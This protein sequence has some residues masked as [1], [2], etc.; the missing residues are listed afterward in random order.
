LKNSQMRT[1]YDAIIVGGGPAGSTAAILLARAGWSVAVIEKQVFPRRKVCGECIAATNLSLLHELGI[2]LQFDSLAGSELRSVGLFAGEEMLQADLP[3][4]AEL[5][6]PWGR[7]LGRE[8]L[9]T[10]LLERAA[11]SGAQIWQPWTLK[12]MERDRNHGRICHVVNAELDATATVSAPVLIAAHGSWEPD[13]FAE[14]HKHRTHR[15]SDLFAFKGTFRDSRL[16]PGLLPVLAFPGGYGGMVLGDHDLLTFAFCPA[17]PRHWPRKHTLHSTARAFVVRWQMRAWRRRGWPSGLS[18][19][20]FVCRGGP[21]AYSRSAMPPERRIRFL[22][23]ASAWRSSRLGCCARCSFH[24]AA[25]LS[26]I[27]AVMKSAVTTLQIG[28]AAS[29]LASVSPRCLRTSRCVLTPSARRCPCSDVGPH[30]SPSARGWVQKYVEW[31]KLTIFP[32]ALRIDDRGRDFLLTHTPAAPSTRNQGRARNIRQR[33]C[34]RFQFSN[35][36]FEMRS[37]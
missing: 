1:D 15:N 32:N 5:L 27:S 16:A 37:A 34:V 20:A 23:R 36:R 26:Q 29:R 35:C 25:R 30:Y 4:F 3:A 2:G 6:H 13:P 12:R 31:L 22:A 10:L 8:H 18:G 24:A 17:C 33:F 28:A 21:M 7:A 11:A 9:D 19:P 14:Q